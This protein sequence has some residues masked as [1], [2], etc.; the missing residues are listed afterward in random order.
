MTIDTSGTWWKGGDFQ[1]LVLFLEDFSQDEFPAERFAKCVC[2]CG[3]SAFH[4]VGNAEAGFAERICAACD[5]AHKVCDSAMHWNADTL[6]VFA[7][8]CG[9][10][11]FELGV[12]FSMR[13]GAHSEE[14][15]WV[16]LGGRC[17]ACGILAAYVEWRVQYMPS[18]HLLTQA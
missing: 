5:S 9:A 8:P 17:L 1:D 16:T 14:V 7:C 6:E 11:V 15:K 10:E 3:E 18:G 2:T 4:C 12:G 13:S